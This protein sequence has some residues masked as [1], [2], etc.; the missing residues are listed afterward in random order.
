MSRKSSSIPGSA[1]TKTV[2]KLFP[3]LSPA[4]KKMRTLFNLLLTMSENQFGG[5][6]ENKRVT[7]KLRTYWTSLEKEEI[8]QR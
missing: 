7:N 8:Q 6:A 4:Q 3:K 5:S 1:K 2:D